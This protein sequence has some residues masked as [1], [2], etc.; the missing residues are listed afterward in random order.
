[1]SKEK[2]QLKKQLLNDVLD[3]LPGVVFRTINDGEWTF[4]YASRGS[5]ALLGYAPDE[6]INVKTLRNMIPEEDQIQNRRILS[7]ISQKNPQ[8]KAVYRV[9][10]ASGKTKWVKE[11]GTGVFSADGRL[12]ALDAFLI[13][14]TDQ[15]MTEEKLREENIRL[16]SNIKDHHRL[17][18]LI[19]K[20]L[21]MRELYDL[22]LKAAGTRA[23]VV[24]TGESGTG[25]ELAARAIH[26]LSDRSE[27]PFIVVNCG[28]VSPNLIESE[29]FGYRK[30]AFS[31]ALS[32]REGL[33]DAAGSGTLFLDEVGE[34]PLNLQIKLLRALDGGGYTRVGGTTVRHSDF[35]LIAATHQHLEDLVRSGRMREDFYYRINAV[36]LRMPPLRER[37]DDI[38]MLAEYF[39][40]KYAHQET[41]PQLSTREERML[42]NYSW[43]GNVRELQNVVYRYLT[44]GTLELTGE[45]LSKET[46]EWRSTKSEEGEDGSLAAGIEQLE[47]KTILD[48]LE[49]HKWHIGKSA[50]ALGYSRRTMQRRMNKYNL[51]R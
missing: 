15:K 40:E 2:T 29:F 9:R 43:P 21:A 24:V 36:R 19:G 39:I 49:R 27:Y 50:A 20:S 22:I 44:L 18:N 14:V 11:E 28:A 16:R 33:L 3:N 41:R 10:T 46:P 47:K 25:K 6:L 48:T 31:G 51:R 8:Y 34:I 5:V 32:D 7:K 37:K 13:D 1:M 4:E 45:V 26:N 30:G 35:R 42:L 23:T 12:E 38:L 17:D